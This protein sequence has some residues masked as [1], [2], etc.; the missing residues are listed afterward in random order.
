MNGRHKIGA[1]A[2]P[3][4]REGMD[5]QPI[6]LKV[7]VQS[8]NPNGKG[9]LHLSP[10]Q[11]LYAHSRLSTITTAF[12]TGH[13]EAVHHL[14]IEALPEDHGDRLNA[15][16]GTRVW[17]IVH[18]GAELPPVLDEVVI[19][20]EHPDGHGFIRLTPDQARYI[21]GRL[22]HITLAFLHENVWGGEDALAQ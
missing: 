20:S 10:D 19:E 6:L 21:H 12:L 3:I 13:P 4:S 16:S 22:T 17:P 1:E 7:I 9:V 8:Q 5:H 15:S 11:A 14:G 2:W 18:E